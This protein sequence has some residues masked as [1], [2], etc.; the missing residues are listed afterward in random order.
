MMMMIILIIIDYDDNNNDVDSAQT[1]GYLQTLFRQEANT[2]MPH[3]PSLQDPGTAPLKYY[4][5]TEIFFQ[6]IEIFY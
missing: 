5:T 1:Q 4:R 6:I 3:F 2:G